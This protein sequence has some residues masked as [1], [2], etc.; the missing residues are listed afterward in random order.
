MSIWDKYPNYSEQ[1]L[2]TLT[3][4]ASEVLM[5]GGGYEVAGMETLDIPPRAAAKEVAEILRDTIPG[6]TANAVQQLFES[7]TMSS[8]LAVQILGVFR[9][10]PGLAELIAA[11]YEQATKR[12]AGIEIILTAALLVLACKIKKFK[13]D[14]NGVEITFAPFS[15]KITALLSLL[16]SKG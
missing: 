14:K 13:L 9:E 10:Q 6:I 11:E 8:D 5:T 12:M 3:K 4:A 2:G 7:R 16:L 15:E 1:E